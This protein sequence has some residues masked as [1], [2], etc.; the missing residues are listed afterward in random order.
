MSVTES[1]FR[2]TFSE[3]ASSTTYPTPEVDFWLGLALK[4]MNADRWGDLLDYGQQLFVAH[5]LAIQ[6]NA[7]ANVD[8]GQAPGQ[9]I[10]AITN[11]SVDKVSYTRDAS[12][13]MLPDA[14]HWNLTTYGIRY[15]QLV[16]MIGAGPLQIGVPSPTDPNVG[17]VA[18]WPGPSL[19]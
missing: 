2:A 13:I 16:R 5:N 14:G 17:S 1:T 8:V 4:M 7:K 3:F 12:S 6:F 9:V 19:W 11:A 10:G 18:G 15:K